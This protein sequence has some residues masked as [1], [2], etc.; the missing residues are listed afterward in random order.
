MIQHGQQK[1]M[2]FTQI[3]VTPWNIGYIGS[4]SVLLH[5]LNNV[6]RSREQYG[7]PRT[8]IFSIFDNWQLYSFSSTLRPS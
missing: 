8:I 7:T 3:Y 4:A 5:M 1:S 6:G 2:L